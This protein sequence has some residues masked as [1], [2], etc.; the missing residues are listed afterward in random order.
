M[1]IKHFISFD[2]LSYKMIY[3]LFLGLSHIII[4]VGHYFLSDSQTNQEMHIDRHIF[5]ITWIMFLVSL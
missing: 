1:S 5:F 4:L 3:P 2:G